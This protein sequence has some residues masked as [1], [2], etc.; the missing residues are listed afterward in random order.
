MRISNIPNMLKAKTTKTVPITMF[1]Q[2]LLASLLSCAA[3]KIAAI[4]TPKMVNVATIDAQ[5]TNA[6]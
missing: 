3:P 1:N 2:G 4:P 6:T 5:N